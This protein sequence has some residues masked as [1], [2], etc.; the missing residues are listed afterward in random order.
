MTF[1][2]WFDRENENISK[3]IEANL[4]NIEDVIKVVAQ[5]AWEAGFDS[6]YKVEHFKLKEE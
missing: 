4:V 3:M 5:S 6:G 2:E 1:E